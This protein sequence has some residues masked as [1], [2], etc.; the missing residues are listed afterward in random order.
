MNG[1]SERARLALLTLLLL[2]VL[3]VLAFATFNTLQAV[4]S[5]QQ[6]YNEVRTGDVSAIHPWMTIHVIS[7]I[8]NVPEDFLYRTLQIGSTVS[9]RRE[10]LYEIATHKRQSVD[11]VIHDIQH[12]ILMYRKQHPPRV[13]PSPTLTP[14]PRLMPIMTVTPKSARTRTPTVT[15]S[16]TPGRT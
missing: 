9:S 10:T 15:P 3:G 4:R 2:V 5:F 8:Y 7:H 13:R 12:A 6:Q 16:S 14:T 1:L 11:Q